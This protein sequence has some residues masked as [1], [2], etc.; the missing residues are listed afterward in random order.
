MIAQSEESRLHARPRYARISVQPSTLPGPDHVYVL[1]LKYNNNHVG[2][3]PGSF[4][5]MP[6]R[7]GDV[8][9]TVSWPFSL[10]EI[11]VL[12]SVQPCVCILP[13]LRL[14]AG[15]QQVSSKITDNTP[16]N[17]PKRT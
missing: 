17:G 3:T 9:E 11:F 6:E 10:P 5:T 7:S 14:E 15:E 4:E 1:F 16:L 12:S 2:T 8:P 13:R